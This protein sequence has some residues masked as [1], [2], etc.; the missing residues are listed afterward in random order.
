[1]KITDA[2]RRLEIAGRVSLV[3]GSGDLPMIWVNTPW[4]AAEI[5]LQGAHVATYQRKTEP[6]MLFLSEESRFDNGQA[7]RGGVPVILPW[8]GAREGQPS[9]GFARTENWDLKE[10]GQTDDGGAWVR[11]ELPANSKASE[12][13]P[14]FRSE[15]TVT[16]GRTLK[17]ELT[18]INASNDR[19]LV[20][21][22]CLH[23]YFNVGDIGAVTIE[24]LSGVDYLDKV[25]NFARKT[26][27]RDAITIASEVDSVYLDA[28]GGVQIRDASLKRLIRV[29]KTG[30]R[31]TVV[32]NPWTAK[33][34]ALTDFGDEEYLKM[35]C[36][37]SGNVGLNKLVIPPGGRHA[38]TVELSSEELT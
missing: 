28:I 37:E 17:L 16:V 3:E 21:E 14:P 12:W 22:N 9:H 4:S 15:Y 34:K 36:V 7:I 38:M 24:G 5:Y 26:E 33:A 27:S 11:L 23:S 19:E 20:V 18:V 13:Q 2:Q 31:S 30:S 35:V 1:M 29:N 10:T 6:S 25:Q 32:W 8:F